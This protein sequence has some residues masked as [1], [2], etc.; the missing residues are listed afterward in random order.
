V[1]GELCATRPELANGETVQLLLHGAT[2]NH[3]YWDFGTI[4]GVSYS[5][6]RDLAAAGFP[7]F[8]LDQ[9]GSGRSS[10]PLSTAISLQ[11]AAYVAHEVVQNLLRGGIGGTRFGK[12]I[13]V[14][15]SL[16]S[17]VA[18]AEAG[19]Y[20]DV[21]GVVIT[22]AV[23]STTVFFSTA[24]GSDFY[25]ASLDPRFVGA[26]V[27]PGYLTT[28][29]GTRGTLFYNG[30]DT[31]PSVVAEDEETKDVFS[32]TELTTGLP[33]LES[34]AATQQ[35]TV[36]VID[37]LGGDD[38]LFCGAEVDGA[39]YDCSSG[40]AVAAEEAPDYAPAAQLRA[41]VVPGS[42]HDINL[43]LNHALEEADAAVW[44]DEYVGQR[45]IPTTRSRTLPIV[46]S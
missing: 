13:V 39:T 25:S 12:V 19:T 42:G 31:N 27:D 10:R 6:A 24:L 35:I 9:I 44:S 14:G 36:P 32:S 17:G 16:G 15:H 21:A 23:H 11:S 33:T 3:S 8:A 34:S 41:C 37:I 46:C 26:G 40:A 22:G 18:W 38:N 28:R 45:G 7:T 2:Y 4:D 5:Y 29:P 43:A 30:A 20:D 1:F